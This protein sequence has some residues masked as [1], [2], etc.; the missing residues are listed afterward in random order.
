MPA[1][2]PT[3]IAP[4]PTDPRVLALAGD[5]G[6]TR[7]EAFAAACEA[8][9]WMTL[10]TTDDTVVKATVTAL[11]TIAE[12]PG[13]GTA[14]VAAGLVGVV[15]GGLVLPAE[16]RHGPRV[17]AEPRS[18]T[19]GEGGTSDADDRRRAAD[20]E[21]QRRYRRRVKVLKPAA[22]TGQSQRDGDSVKRVP[23]RLG[24][25]AGYA[26]MLL[27]S[28]SGVPFYK[29]AGASPKEWTGTVTD[30]ENPTLADAFVALH[31][32]MK[33]G[34][35]WTDGADMR[36]TVEQVVAAAERYRAN[37]ESVAAD[38][39]R[40]DEANR[41]LAEAVADDDDDAGVTPVTRDCHAPVTPVTR[42][43]V[44]VTLVSRSE[45]VTP[46]PNVSTGQDLGRVTCHAPVT[47][48]TPSSS[49][50]SFSVSSM[51]DISGEKTT[52][53]SSVTDAERDADRGRD[54]EVDILDRLLVNANPTSANRSRVDPEGE[55]KRQRIAEVYARIADALGDDV[56]MVKIRNPN[57]L[58]LQC[59]DAG[60]DPNT[61]LPVAAEGS[62]EPVVTRRAPQANRDRLL[63]ARHAAGILGAPRE[64]DFPDDPH[65]L[66][67]ALAGQGIQPPSVPA[68]P[69]DA[70]AATATDTAADTDTATD[71]GAAEHAMMEEFRRGA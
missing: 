22:A 19:A 10:Q 69:D 67:R 54:R 21:R 7:R 9:S 17:A 37:R 15:D 26:V 13:F 56:E 27:F 24:D 68:I 71:A 51:E 57:Y 45:G 41:A 8:W 14:M 18:R 64:C 65:A 31:A 25:V 30:P 28:R 42:D 46:P 47:R 1:T 11:D 61:G 50:S 44:T 32:Q 60:I 2:P 16:L 40:R 48:D 62:H 3:I 55:V 63:R 33:R 5:I 36:P 29:L 39:D 6:M 52:T 20:R 35:G 34:H 4:T 58:A 66:R 23:R 49:S 38:D 53:T 43:T 12:V 70:D 59:R